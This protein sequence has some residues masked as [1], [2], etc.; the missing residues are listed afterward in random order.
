MLKRKFN[1]KKLNLGS[2]MR[3]FRLICLILIIFDISTTVGFSISSMK[4]NS[5][6]T[7]KRTESRISEYIKSV[8]NLGDAIA[9]S[10][11][12]LF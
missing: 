4:E 1:L 8:W 12:H 5:L 11:T 9:V 10:Y 3:W 2:L 6:D 7:I